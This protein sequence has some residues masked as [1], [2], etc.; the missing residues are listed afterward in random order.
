MLSDFPT[1]IATKLSGLN[2]HEAKAIGMKCGISQSFATPKTRRI[3]VGW[4]DD[5]NNNIKMDL[6]E[7]GFP[8]DWIALAEDR[9]QWLA[10]VRA[11]M[12]LRVP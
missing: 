6:K 12:N 5:I 3:K 7:V 10:Y 2:K 9:D 11:V 1:K 4:E 8:A